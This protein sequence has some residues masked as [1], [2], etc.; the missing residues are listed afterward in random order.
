MKI[1]LA[2]LDE[3]PFQIL[4][5]NKFKEVLIESC[6]LQEMIERLENNVE[7]S[8]ALIH[9]LELGAIDVNIPKPDAILENTKTIVYN[10][11][12]LEFLKK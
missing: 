7:V 4:D 1:Y 6:Q 3:S 5:E 11:E 2:E 9:L 12:V 8:K 10:T